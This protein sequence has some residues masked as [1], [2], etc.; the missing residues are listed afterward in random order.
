M[1][2]VAYYTNKPDN[3][4]V[5]QFVIL[6]PIAIGKESGYWLIKMFSRNNAETIG[7][8]RDRLFLNIDKTNGNMV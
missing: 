3:W 2:P 6:I 4:V 8:G 5:G 7:S 1:L